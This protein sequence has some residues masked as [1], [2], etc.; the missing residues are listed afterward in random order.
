MAGADSAG[1]A[2]EPRG[3]GRD[4]GSG[5]AVLGTYFAAGGERGKE[6]PGTMVRGAGRQG[7]L[8][9]FQPPAPATFLLTP[10]WLLFGF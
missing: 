10:S 5:K 8:R 2:S 7:L 6:D 4:H 1:C 3:Q 9:L